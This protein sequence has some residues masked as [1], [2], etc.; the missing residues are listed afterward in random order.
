MKARRNPWDF[1]LRLDDIL[2]EGDK[3]MF[4]KEII[5]MANDLY[6]LT[7]KCPPPEHLTVDEKILIKKATCIESWQPS[8]NNAEEQKALCLGL[9]VGRGK[10]A[11][12]HMNYNEDAL[13][14]LALNYHK[15]EGGGYNFG[16]CSKIVRMLDTIDS[17]LGWDQKYPQ[18]GLLYG[19]A[20]G[21]PL[22]DV[23][24]F[25]RITQMPEST[26]HYLKK[27][28]KDNRYKNKLDYLVHLPTPS[29]WPA[30]WTKKVGIEGEEYLNSVYKKI[31]K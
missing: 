29:V 28:K 17:S 15:R 31:L 11:G 20:Y 2:E 30:V 8:N 4:S 14:G 26:M 27:W 9:V 3:K 18:E 1:G 7:L 25:C 24:G 19:I 5:D 6:D 12:E 22:G 16:Y 13:S 21:F 23:V 10:P